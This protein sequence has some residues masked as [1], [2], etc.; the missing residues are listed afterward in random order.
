MGGKLRVDEVEIR[1]GVK[2][3]GGTIILVTFSV[4]TASFALAGVGQNIKIISEAQIAGNMA[5]DVIDHV[6]DVNPDA[7]T[8]KHNGSEL[9]IMSVKKD[10]LEGKIEFKNVKFNYPSREDLQILKDFSATMEAGKT[11]A[12]VGPSGSGK[13]TII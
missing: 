2:Y 7:K 3:D 4:V 12:L 13:S 8:Y 11:T 10:N 5:Y 1:D 9:P 6:P